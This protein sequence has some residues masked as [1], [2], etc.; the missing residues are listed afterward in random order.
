MRASTLD[1]YRERVI[2]LRKVKAGEIAVN[3]GEYKYFDSLKEFC[4]MKGV[5]FTIIAYNSLKSAANLVNSNGESSVLAWGE[6]K[7]LFHQAKDTVDMSM[8]SVSPLLPNSE[9][10]AEQALLDAHICSM[11]FLELLGFL[12]SLSETLDSNPG[13]AADKVRIQLEISKAK[14]KSIISYANNCFGAKP[15]LTLIK[16][17]DP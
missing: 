13:L 1:N 5:S 9:I 12:S 3:P 4:K 11:A 7:F 16:N 8:A 10:L 15:A 14:F 17:R 2:W 6:L